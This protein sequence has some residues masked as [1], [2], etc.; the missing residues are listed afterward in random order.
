MTNGTNG[1]EILP[2]E[3]GTHDGA[4]AEL[5]SAATDARRDAFGMGP[6]TGS[7]GPANVL[8]RPGAFGVG[9]VD[10]TTLVSAA[11]ASPALEDNAR[12]TR[13]IPG[14]M[15]ISSVATAP[16][17][18]GEGLGRRVVLA[19]LLH[20][21]RRGYARTQLWTHASNPVS[22]HLYESMG[23]AL[24]GRVM[25]DDFGEDVVH[26]LRELDASPMPPRAAARILCCDDEDRVILLHWRD[27]YDGFRLWEPPGG[28]IEPGESPREAV[29][30]EWAEETGL[31]APELV[32]E[33]VVVGRDLYWLG[34]RYVGDEHFFLAR[35]ARAEP[36]DVSGQTEI[37]QTAY[38]GHTWVHW[39]EIADLDDSDEP[40][41]V[42]V[43]RRL[44]PTGP[45][46]ARG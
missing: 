13:S 7:G 27:P 16:A 45:W 37:E 19:I 4:L 30:R 22:R 38:L 2:L 15:H 40:D 24:S 33:P 34:D 35:T 5:W 1:L 6:L 29:L 18:W 44:D 25:I 8:T 28:G 26:Y 14:V 41:V 43:L 39:S 46:A 32:G 42:A 31:P 10:G 9:I 17:R 23:F 3:R 11:V 21:K 12:S 20:G 36:P